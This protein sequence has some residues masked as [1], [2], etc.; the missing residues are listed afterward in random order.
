MRVILTKKDIAQAK[1]AAALRYQLARAAGVQDKLI[2]KNHSCESVDL[3]GIKAEIAFAKL[4]GSDF[5]ANALGIDSGVDIY[6]KGLRGEF[7]VQVKS[8]HHKDAEWL[9]INA[10]PDSEWDVVA[11]VL[12]TDHDEVMEVRG[13]CSKN[14]CIDLQET[15]DLGHGPTVGVRAK[16]LTCPS[17]LWK[18][19]N[20]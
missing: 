14:R 19:L 3:I 6:V 13:I 16:N 20:A 1:Q 12:P 18:N 4:F 2:G 8:S 15:T 17:V 10:D 7:G 9:L 5:E 11:L